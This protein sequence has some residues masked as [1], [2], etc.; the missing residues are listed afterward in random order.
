MSN[1]A[2]TAELAAKSLTNANNGVGQTFAVLVNEELTTVVVYLNQTCNDI[3]RALDTPQIRN[4]EFKTLHL[5][6]QYKK[7]T[8]ILNI[9]EAQ[10]IDNYSPNNIQ[11]TA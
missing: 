10:S 2:L 3:L 1:K 9:L 6:A 5:N 4:N 11:A 7:L 8:D